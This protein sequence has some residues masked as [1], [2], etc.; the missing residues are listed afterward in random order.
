MSEEIMN[1]NYEKEDYDFLNSLPKAPMNTAAWQAFSRPEEITIEWHHTEDQGAVGSCQGNS[2]SS[3]LERV[4]LVRGEQVQ[5]SR[6]F[7]YLASQKIDGFLGADNG[8]TIAGGVKMALDV[9]CPPESLT[10]YVGRYPNRTERAKILSPENYEA[11]APYKA[12]S[13]WRCD[14]DVEAIA[15]WIAGGGA[16]NFGIRWH[17]GVIP[18]DRIVR[19][20]RPGRG[21]HAMAILGYT[22]DLDLRAVNSHGD[23]PYIITKAAW[24]QMCA[25]DYTVAIG[26]MGNKTAQPIDWFKDSP[27]FKLRMKP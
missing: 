10:G 2:I 9:G 18:A 27:Y 4:A 15:D 21:G 14:S 24:K 11:A 26:I 6:M 16:I 12:L 5:L 25:Y 23:G 3:C 7:A 17:G 8:S 19:S 22:K 20:Y 13:A 1:W